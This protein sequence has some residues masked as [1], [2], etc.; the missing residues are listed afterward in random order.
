[1][2]RM[3]T[4]TDIVIPQELAK[5]KV[6]DLAYDGENIWV[7]TRNGLYQYYI[8]SKEWSKFT[9]QHGLASN[10][11]STVAVDVCKRDACT[12]V[13][14]GTADAGISRYDKAKSE[15]QSFDIDD[16]IAGNNIR[17]ISIDESYVWFGTFSGGLCRYDKTSGLWTTYR[18]AEFVTHF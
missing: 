11:I 16:G 5:A 13:W 8:P 3:Y 1:M 7:S 4:S 6:T 2:F 9:T 10:R 12:T 14:I 17:A 15:W 18:T